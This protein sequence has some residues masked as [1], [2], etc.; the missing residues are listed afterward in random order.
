MNFS[1]VI[2]E[3][4]FENEDRIIWV[5]T[6]QGLSHWKLTESASLTNGFQTIKDC[7]ICCHFIVVQAYK[8]ATVWI[9]ISYS[10]PFKNRNANYTA[11]L[12]KMIQCCSN[13]HFHFQ[14]NRCKQVVFQQHQLQSLPLFAKLIYLGLILLPLK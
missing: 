4:K 13:S 9:F 6:C 7:L 8:L 12:L 14:Q 10:S 5:C 1:L 11:I 2:C 3:K